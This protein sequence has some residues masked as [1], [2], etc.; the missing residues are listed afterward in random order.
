MERLGHRS[1]KD[2]YTLPRTYEPASLLTV[3]LSINYRSHPKL[4][5][6]PS[7]IFYDGQLRSD[8]RNAVMYS[9]CRWRGLETA[10]FPFVFAGVEVRVCMC[11]CVRARARVYM[12]ECV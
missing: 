5:E 8:G 7:R 12:S 1:H 3:R 2:M 11:A 4:L 9:L 10:G 6:L